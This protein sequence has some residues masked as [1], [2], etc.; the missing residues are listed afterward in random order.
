MTEFCPFLT[1]EL[2]QKW[3][4][5]SRKGHFPRKWQNET[6]FPTFCLPSLVISGIWHVFDYF[7]DLSLIKWLYITTLV[8]NKNRFMLVRARLSSKVEKL[9]G[10][11]QNLDPMRVNIICPYRKEEGGSNRDRNRR[12]NFIWISVWIWY[13]IIGW[14][15]YK[16]LMVQVRLESSHFDNRTCKG[17][18]NV[19]I[20]SILISFGHNN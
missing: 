2:D 17:V 10:I 5:R 15:K 20:K 14:R 1:T 18:V 13:E 8:S 4:L 9:N 19:L 11:G 12:H 7:S 16:I 6:P 3:I